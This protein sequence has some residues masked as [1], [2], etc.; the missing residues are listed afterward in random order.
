MSHEPAEE[1][2]RK[3][4]SAVQRYLPPGGLDIKDAMREIISAVDPWPLD[5]TTQVQPD[6]ITQRI[7]DTLEGNQP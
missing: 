4:L 6:A 2:L 1:A 5:R 3:V 7:L